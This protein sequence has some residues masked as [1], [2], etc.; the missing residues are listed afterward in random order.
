MKF[1]LIQ[2]SGIIAVVLSWTIGI[3]FIQK[4]KEQNSKNTLL[5]GIL[6]IYALMIISSLI[7]SAGIHSELF[8][9]AHVSN[10]SMFLIGPLLYLYIK[11]Q[12]DRNYQLSWQ[13]FIHGIPFLVAT[14]YLILKFNFI[15][16]PI[17]CRSNHILV[18]SIA[19]IHSLVYFSFSMRDLKR[20]GFHIKSSFRRLKDKKAGLLPFLVYGCFFIWLTKLLFFLAWDISGFYQGCNELVNLYF[21]VSFI[22]LIIFTYFILLKPNYFK[23]DEK[24]KNSLLTP[25]EK[26]KYKK[27]LLSLMETEKAFLNPLISLNHLA[28]HM[29][30]PTRYLSQVINETMHKSFYEL[31]NE[32]RVQEC[33]KYFSDSNHSHKTILE[34]AYEAGFNSKSTFNTSFTKY[35]GVTP[36]E[37]RKNCTE[38]RD[39]EV[40]SFT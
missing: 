25:S 6:F 22:L 21:L 8:T 23:S 30:V 5:S 34:I 19:F 2:T 17:T 3:Y 39:L 1:D 38:K 20:T 24:Y 14:L 28:K 4:R 32:Y 7:L 11:L 33:L 37:F 35:V 16:I 36:K 27:A 31:I 12:L 13:A 18:G 15:Q 26:S 9:W 29:A 10:Q 40:I